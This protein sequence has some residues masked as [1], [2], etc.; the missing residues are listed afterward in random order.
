MFVGICRTT[1]SSTEERFRLGPNRW[2]QMERN[3]FLV[4]FRVFIAANF[5]FHILEKFTKEL[6]LKR[7]IPV[8]I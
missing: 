7:N 1:V 2:N 3:S 4:R 6:W 5:D 8:I